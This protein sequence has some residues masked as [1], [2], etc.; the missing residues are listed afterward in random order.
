MTIMGDIIRKIIQHGE[1]NVK[2]YD[3]VS[4][5]QIIGIHKKIAK[6]LINKKYNDLDAS[7][8]SGILSSMTDLATVCI[9]NKEKFSVYKIIENL[10][11]IGES[12]KNNNIQKTIDMIFHIVKFDDNGT[13]SYFHHGVIHILRVLIIM[14]TIRSS[15]LRQYFEQLNHF[16]QSMSIIERN[17]LFSLLYFNNIDLLLDYVNNTIQAQKKQEIPLR[18]AKSNLLSFLKFIKNVRPSSYDKLTI[19][20][21]HNFMIKMKFVFDNESLEKFSDICSIIDLD[22]DSINEG[23]RYFES[24]DDELLHEQYNSYDT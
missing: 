5:N 3:L 17:K 4:F 12:S 9:S 13:Q 8:L 22:I 1:Y 23:V 24:I 15:Y 18:I 6:F 21:T 19:D 11:D 10:A 2:N 7:P 20:I 16:I 14:T